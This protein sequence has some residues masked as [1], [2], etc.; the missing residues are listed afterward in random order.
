MPDQK[1]LLDSQVENLIERIRDR[2]RNLYQTRQLLCTEAVMVAL[3]QGLDG[4]LRD[5]QAVS[6]AAPFSAAIGESGCI[7][8]ALSGAVMASG[9]FLGSG[10][11]YRYRQEIRDS[12]R[13]LHDAFK[14]ANGAT[15]CRVL[16]RKFGNDQGAL[17]RRCTDLTAEAADLAARLI[18]EKRPELVDRADTVFLARSESKIGG[19]LARLFRCLSVGS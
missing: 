3:N 1:K 7:C 10:R 18:L 5:A 12:A 8:G 2:A 16:S 6:M 15:C 11:P 17:F 14:A 13:H 4:G 19:A 9:L